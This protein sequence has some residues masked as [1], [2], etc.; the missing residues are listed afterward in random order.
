MPRLL[1]EKNF[2]LERTLYFART[3]ATRANIYGFRG[4][5]YQNARALHIGRPSAFGDTMGVADLVPRHHAF[6]ANLA[7][8]AHDYTSF[9]TLRNM[10]CL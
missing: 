5:V 7:V 8:L 4:A 2:S 10:Y 9:K 1:P 3:Q 6:M